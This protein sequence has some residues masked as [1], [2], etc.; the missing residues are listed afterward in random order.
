M[1][2][3]KPGQVVPLPASSPWNEANFPPVKQAEERQLSD[4][5]IHERKR[6]VH[7]DKR[8]RITGAFNSVYGNGL[9]P[10]SDLPAAPPQPTPAARFPSI[11]PVSGTDHLHE[12]ITATYT[13]SQTELVTHTTTPVPRT[14]SSDRISKLKVWRDEPRPSTPRDPIAVTLKQL[15][16]VTDTRNSRRP[17]RIP[18]EK[19]RFRVEG[20]KYHHLNLKDFKFPQGVV[21]SAEE[22]VGGLSQSEEHVPIIEASH[23]V[24]DARLEP[25]RS[26]KQKTVT[27]VEGVFAVQ[28]PHQEEQ[29]NSKVPEKVETHQASMSILEQISKKELPPLVNEYES[30]LWPVDLPGDHGSAMDTSGSEFPDFD[31]DAILGGLS[32]DQDYPTGDEDASEG[33]GTYQASSPAF[34]AATVSQIAPNVVS[35]FPS[36][37][38]KNDQHSIK[39][40]LAYSTGYNPAHPHHYKHYLAQFSDRPAALRPK[41][42]EYRHM[43]QMVDVVNLNQR[44]SWMLLMSGE[45]PHLFREMTTPPPLIDSELARCVRFAQ[46]DAQRCVDWR[47]HPSHV[48]DIIRRTNFYGMELLVSRSE[49]RISSPPTLEEF[50]LAMATR[51]AHV[52]FGTDKMDYIAADVPAMMDYLLNNLPSAMCVLPTKGEDDFSGYTDYYH[53]MLTENYPPLTVLGLPA[54]RAL[55]NAE[56]DRPSL[57]AQSLRSIINAIQRQAAQLPSDVTGAQP[58]KDCILNKKPELIDQSLRKYRLKL[59]QSHGVGVDSLDEADRW[60]N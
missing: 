31:L 55:L 24:Q 41:E 4:A 23:R 47:A 1:S 2:I 17:R 52:C 42:R 46:S 21:A 29:E 33:F 43:P 34:E 59:G 7:G 35:T 20:G 10:T 51:L 5:V 54:W 39:M 16:D 13:P 18:L 30:P 40:D 26:A 58:W 38:D 19:P 3:P 57:K 44:L 15:P 28:A 8:R 53:A 32:E 45:V 37:V 50:E 11:D 49:M 60:N 25:A 36:W 9:R 27:P 22:K 12:S 48:A 14:K 56:G 6:R